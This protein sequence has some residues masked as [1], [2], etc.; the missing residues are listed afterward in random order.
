MV[1]GCQNV[2]ILLWLANLTVNKIYYII[3]LIKQLYFQY[4]ILKYHRILQGIILRK[5]TKIKK[6]FLYPI[7]EFLASLV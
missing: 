5:E 4:H 3:N 7:R 2:T 6:Y 1:E